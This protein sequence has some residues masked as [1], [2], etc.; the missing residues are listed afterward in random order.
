MRKSTVS[1]KDRFPLWQPLTVRDFRL[2]Y[3]GESV[4]LLG[5]QFYL[6]ALPW[7]TIQLTH[8]P[9]SLG[10]V[11]MAA[12]IPRAVL[13][14]IGGVFSDRLSPR[15]IMLVS[16]GLRAVLTV[17][18]TALIMFRRTQLWHLYVFA[19]S[20]GVVDGFFIPA[21]KSIIPT[22]VTKELLAA[23]NALSQGTTQLLVLIGPALGGLLISSIGIET[24]FAIDAATFM[25]TSV[26]L[27]LMK[28]SHQ[29][30]P[31]SISAG[32]L[33]NLFGSIREGLNYVWNNREL[34]VVLLVVTILNF[35][36]VGP[37]QVG[38]TSLAQ[39]RFLGGAIALGIM[40]SAWGGGGLLGTLMPGIFRRL[41]PVGILMLTLAS[42]QG[43]GLFLLGFLPSILLASVTIAVLGSCSSFF[44]VV[45]ITWIQKQTSPEMLGRVISLGMLSSFG[46]A[47]FSYALAGVLADLNITTLFTATGG[48][49]LIISV[50]LMINRSLR[51]IN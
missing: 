22:L 3:I 20:F 43:F 33:V 21:A 6:V 31:E 14:L 17:L 25:F 26:T 41:P 51:S 49:M 18:L 35:I 2:L 10:T 46:V 13:M 28:S 24:A 30:S 29:S 23:S 40:N 8:S 44:T 47:P 12:A 38:I 36:F 39:S 27:L 48:F 37:I 19:L 34:R 11:L 1:S 50:L 45:A 9:I 5:D 16:N 15:F 4:S 32:R 42:I 7:L